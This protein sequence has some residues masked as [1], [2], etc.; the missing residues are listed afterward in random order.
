MAHFIE[1][2]NDIN[3]DVIFIKNIDNVV[4]D[5]LKESEAHYKKLLAGV[6]V[7]MQERAH[8]YL[9]ILIQDFNSEDLN[10][11]LSFTKNELNIQSST[12]FASDDDLKKYLKQKLDRPFR[13]RY[14]KE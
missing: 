6:L 1:N 10:E 9:E 14:G 13:V 4:P 5:R 8:D 12:E 7:T 11:M 3:S 2:L